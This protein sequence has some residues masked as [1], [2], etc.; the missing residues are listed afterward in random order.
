MELTS[1]RFAI[2]LASGLTLAVVVGLAVW[3]ISDAGMNLTSPQTEIAGQPIAAA[4]ADKSSTPKTA[5][6][7]E[8]SSTAERSEEETSADDA[9]AEFAGEA[10]SND[11][12]GA[13]GTGADAAYD[14]LAPRN[15]NLGGARGGS[16]ETSYYRPTNAAPAQPNART[17][18]PEQTQ[19][20]DNSPRKTATPI[21]TT[22]VPQ[23]PQ[24]KPVPGND[25]DGAAQHE[26]EP[27]EPSVDA[28]AK[29][30]QIA[31]DIAEKVGAGGA[32]SGAVNGQGGEKPKRPEDPFSASTRVPQAPAEDDGTERGAE[33]NG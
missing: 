7:S 8:A 19:Q 1:R 27:Q 6:S 28:G 11:S 13:Q 24:E 9:D 25:P 18:A 14:P 22:A 30:L 26:R 32:V 17:S 20:Q 21:S 4:D 15:A 23:K 12:N 5:A 16:Q 29:H 33:A 2:F 10:A 3:K 31:S